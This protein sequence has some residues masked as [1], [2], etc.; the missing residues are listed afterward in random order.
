MITTLL[1]TLQV[2]PVALFYDPISTSAGTSGLQGMPREMYSIMVYN[3]NISEYTIGIVT[4]MAI[5]S[6]TAV[7]I[8]FFAIFDYKN[9]RR[10]M[11]L[12]RVGQLLLLIWGVVYALM[13]Y[14]ETTSSVRVQFGLCLPIVSL[15]LF[16]LAYKGIKHDD[17][18]VRSADRLR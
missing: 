11:L 4:I 9:R 17:D 18:L 7:M 3:P 8:A 16:Q 5:A 12:C 14:T 10:Q 15:I 13:V 6:V 1:I 2:L